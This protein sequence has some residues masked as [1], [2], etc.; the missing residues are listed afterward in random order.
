MPEL[1]KLVIIRAYKNRVVNVVTHLYDSYVIYR[2]KTYFEPGAYSALA[3][4]SHY[5]LFRF[6]LDS[7]GMPEMWYKVDVLHEIWL[8]YEGSAIYGMYHN[9]TIVTFQ[10]L[11]MGSLPTYNLLG[12]KLFHTPPPVTTIPDIIHPVSVD[13]E[14]LGD[15]CHLYPYISPA[16]VRWWDAFIDEQIPIHCLNPEPLSPEDFWLVITEPPAEDLLSP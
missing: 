16:A 8:G 9:K 4:H 1:I 14:S 12:I 3:N 7:D 6:N 5:R 10:P 11:N 2:W 13:P 15:I